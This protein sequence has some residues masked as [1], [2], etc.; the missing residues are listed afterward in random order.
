MEAVVARSVQ[1]LLALGGAYLIALWFTL[2]VWAFR[3]IETRSRSVIT[4]IVS[5]LLV[6]LFFVPGLLLYMIL[7]PKET[8]DV[9]FQRSLEEEYL[10]QDLEELPLCPTCQH[11]VSDDF[12]LC[13]H[14]QTQLRDA[15]LACTRLVDLRWPICPYCAADQGRGVAAPPVVTPLAQPTPIAPAIAPEPTE[16]FERPAVAAMPSAPRPSDAAVAL[17]VVGDAATAPLRLFDRRKTREMAQ[18]A[19]QNGNK[20]AVS[21]SFELDGNA[22][23]RVDA[24][25]T[26]ATIGDRSVR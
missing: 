2:I 6:V 15:C 14:C 24:A 5:T 8:L 12:Q 7:R 16:Q 23:Q 4:Q 3:D 1:V 22:D 26:P 9:A 10:L 17:T 21:N 25:R 13:P 18:A 20:H 11:Y 19:T